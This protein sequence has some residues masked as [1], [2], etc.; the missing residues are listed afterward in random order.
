M[1]RF[2][3]TW[4]HP[5]EPDV[6]F[7]GAYGTE[8][9]P[10]TLLKPIVAADGPVPCDL[11]VVGEAPS[12]EEIK[13]GRPFVGPS[14]GIL[15]GKQDLIGTIVGRARETVF[16]TNVC[17]IPMPDDEWQKLS[18][19]ERN[20]YFD[21]L[22]RE[23]KLVKPK[24]VLCFGRRACQALVPAFQGV[25]ND[26][27]KARLGA[28]FIVLPL[29]HPSAFLRGNRRVLDD[30]TVDLAQVP[31]LLENGLAPEDIQRE[32]ETWGPAQE[33]PV[34]WPEAVGFLVRTTEKTGK[35]ILCGGNLVCGRYEGRGVKWLLCKTHAV[36]S[37][38]WA[39]QNAPALED[40]SKLVEEDKRQSLLKKRCA[41]IEKVLKGGE[42]EVA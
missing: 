10:S 12:H 1:G 8:E 32:E 7:V 24:L 6:P 35:C 11:A 28:G 36:I 17:K 3:M 23:L 38:E 40:H 21:E 37:A 18:W 29:W 13:Q 39:K 22:R 5:E 9:I 15:W 2:C 26:H 16:V 30:L 41:R 31:D 19:R 42:D 4:P 20:P 27:G 33:A 14:G 25:Q 34:P